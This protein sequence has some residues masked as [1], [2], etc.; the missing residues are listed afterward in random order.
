MF[1]S[2]DCSFLSEPRAATLRL[3][4]GRRPQRRSVAPTL[5]ANTSSD[6]DGR[7]VRTDMTTRSGVNYQSPSKRES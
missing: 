7:C 1:V 2:F 6:A 5:T 3:D 4:Y